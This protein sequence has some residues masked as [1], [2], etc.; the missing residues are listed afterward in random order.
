M[1]T[2]QKAFNRKG[3][4]LP[5]IF[6]WVLNYTQA[7][8]S[9]ETLSKS[10][11][12]AIGKESLEINNGTI[13]INEFRILNNK[14]RYYP[15]DKFEAGTVTYNNQN[16]YDVAI[17][18]DIY[19]DA[20]IYRPQASDAVSLNLIQD[21]VTSFSI[22][23]KKFVYLHSLSLPLAQLKT[24]Y[25]EE[26]VLG[27]KFI[28]YIRH[29][30][31]KREVLKG[32]SVFHEFDDN[33]EYFIKKEGNFHKISTKKDIIKLFPEYKRKINDFYFSSK[34]LLKTDEPLFY[35]KLMTYL[36]NATENYAD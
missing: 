23:N 21:K 24:G 5:I 3:L 7:Q 4:I 36:N 31:D 14:H 33:Y 1:K 27:K 10:F 12:L 30:R 22:N 26:N 9:E 35:E 17:K 15:T 20:I 19:K 2:K 29:H 6:F 28:F 32:S 16:Y 25:Y 11:D 34:K 18:Y 13:H 8:T